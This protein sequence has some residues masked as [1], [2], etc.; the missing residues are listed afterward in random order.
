MIIFAEFVELLAHLLTWLL[1]L[2]HNLTTFLVLVVTAP[3]PPTEEEEEQEKQ[4]NKQFGLYSTMLYSRIYVD[5]NN[6]NW[7]IF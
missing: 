7:H 1:I 2:S 4:W 6:L 3:P 5:K